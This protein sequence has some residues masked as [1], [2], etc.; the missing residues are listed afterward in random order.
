MTTPTTV[1]LDDLDLDF[2]P[3]C[4]GLLPGPDG[5]WSDPIPCLHPA[6]WIAFFVAYEDGSPCPKCE[7]YGKASCVGHLACDLHRDLWSH[8]VQCRQSRRIAAIDHLEML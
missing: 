7:F 2:P 8:R 3:P 5:H 6:K 4:D 1:P